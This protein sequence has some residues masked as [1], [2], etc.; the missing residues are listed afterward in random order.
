M[1][2]GHISAISKSDYD[3]VKSA[4][5]SSNR[6]ELPKSNWDCHNIIVTHY[7]LECKVI[8]KKSQN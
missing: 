7:T 3:C 5:L 2:Y 6:L 4:K 1:P 8:K